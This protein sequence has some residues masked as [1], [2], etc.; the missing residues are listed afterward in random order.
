[1]A[2]TMT[3]EERKRWDFECSTYQCMMLCDEWRELWQEFMRKVLDNRAWDD[4]SSR[5]SDG[6][7]LL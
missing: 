5:K 6:W 1:M 4:A 7:P 2:R 3:F